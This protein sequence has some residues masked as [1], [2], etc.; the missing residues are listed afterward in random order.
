MNQK[1][2]DGKAIFLTSH[3]VEIFPVMFNEAI[4]S[5]PSA[6]EVKKINLAFILS[7]IIREVMVLEIIQI[8]NQIMSMFTLKK[9]YQTRVSYLGK[10]LT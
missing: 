1:E 10:L 3:L 6:W 2:H 5:T 7:I 4:T 8:I 9:T